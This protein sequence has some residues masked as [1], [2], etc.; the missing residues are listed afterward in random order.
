MN[1]TTVQLSEQTNQ[2]GKQFGKILS[3][4]GP[5]IGLGLII[6]LFSFLEP[7]KFPTYFNFL[8]VANQTVIVTLAAGEQREDGDR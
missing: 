6:L 1:E 2:K 5:F 3:I 8:T 4:I 7:G